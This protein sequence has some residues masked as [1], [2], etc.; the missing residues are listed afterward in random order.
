MK[1]KVKHLYLSQYS[2]ANSLKQSLKLILT[3]EQPRFHH[4]FDGF[5]LLKPLRFRGLIAI[6]LI[7]AL[8]QIL[9]QV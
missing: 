6:T 9:Y 1:K 7:F 3:A 8:G 4:Y 5:L 2:I